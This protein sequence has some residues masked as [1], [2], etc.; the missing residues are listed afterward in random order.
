MRSGGVDDNIVSSVE[1]R[2][3]VMLQ[4]VEKPCSM[5]TN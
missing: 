3:F 1:S 2:Q 5:T 4:I